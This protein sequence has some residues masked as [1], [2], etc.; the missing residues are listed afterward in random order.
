[1][2]TRLDKNDRKANIIEEAEALFLAQGYGLTE[3]ED[4]RKACGISRGGLYHHFSNKAAILD[5]LVDIEVEN[6]A[7]SI[8][9]A[10]NFLA[11]LLR[12]SSSQQ[13]QGLLE[14]FVTT[15]E[16]RAYLSA[17]DLAL[18]KYLMPV[19]EEGLVSL[20]LPGVRPDHVAELFLTVNAHINRRVVLGEWSDEEASQ[21]AGT[22]LVALTS[23]LKDS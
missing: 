18:T 13:E 1:M 8:T 10:P 4:I 14:A 15:E 5:A 7:M 11:F 23:F 12:H 3:M 17:L 6:L 19:L 21:F 16:K 2:R 22:A 9:K 20:V